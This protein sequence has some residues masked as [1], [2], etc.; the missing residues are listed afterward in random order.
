M[1]SFASFKLYFFIRMLL[2]VQKIK[3]NMNKN[4]KKYSF[5]KMKVDWLECKNLFSLQFISALM[6]SFDPINFKPKH[7]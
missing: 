2:K 7:D 5:M 3:N 6:L 4:Y 1:S